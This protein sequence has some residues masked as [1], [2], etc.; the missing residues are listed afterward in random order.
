MR[1]DGIPEAVSAPGTLRTLLARVEKALPEAVQLRHEL[2]QHPDVSGDEGRTA[3]RLLRALGDVQ[4]EEVA[5]TGFVLRVGPADGP[6][7]G[8]RAELDALPVQEK[9]AVGF[10]STNGNM[11][12]CGHDVHMAGAFALAR[13]AVQTELPVALLFIFQPREEAYPSG[14]KDILLSEVLDRHSVRSVVGVHV[15]PQ[16]A[17]GAITTG[18]GAVNAAADEFR[19][20]V[21]A[22]GGHAAYPHKTSDAIVAL[23]QIV[24]AA[25]TLV[26]RRINPM[27]PAVV[28]FGAL[29]SGDAANVIPAVAEASGSIRSNTREDRAALADGM[30]EIV[31]LVARAHGCEGGLEIIS[32]EPV[33]SN[34]RTVVEAVDP[35]LAG[36]GFEVV[37]PHRSCGSDDFS[38]YSDAYPSIMMFL[39]VGPEGG[40][41][42]LHHPGFVPPD[43][44]VGAVARAFACA[45]AAIAPLVRQG[46]G[47]GGLA[48]G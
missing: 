13:A 36:H 12:A 40:A 24:T 28:T 32:G 16:V 4:Y 35:V 5:E 47:E 9:S 27:H 7:V 2:H 22:G 48:P 31:E 23:A 14:A 20:R 42:S 44:S 25:Q 45:F 34:D 21:S 18:A 26:S 8:I 17:A 37:E 3:E 46:P 38:Y 19:V 43:W 33:L 39:G 1:T 6:A 15:Q 11:H 29:R 30:R 10:A 41:P